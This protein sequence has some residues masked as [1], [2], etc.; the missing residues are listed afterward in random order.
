MICRGPL[1]EARCFLRFDTAI[2]TNALPGE[3]ATLLV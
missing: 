1:L 2:T 3:T